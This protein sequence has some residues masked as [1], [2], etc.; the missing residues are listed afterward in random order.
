[1][2]S[3][4][5]D[6]GGTQGGKRDPNQQ[7]SNSLLRASNS[8]VNTNIEQGGSFLDQAKRVGGG[9][10][11]TTLDWLGRPGQAVL[12]GIQA[13]QTHQGA[14]GILRGL[15]R[16]FTGGEHG[17]QWRSD[18]T[19]NLRG[20]L[21]TDNYQVDGGRGGINP[22]AE[23]A[24]E[25]D[26]A[27]KGLGGPLETIGKVATG[28]VDFLGSSVLDPSTFVT[29]G[30][31]KAAKVGAEAAAKK[32]A[33]NGAE[34]I[35]TKVAANAG[36]RKI[37]DVLTDDEM[38]VLKTAIKNSDE[39]AIAKG[40][41]DKFT[42]K[43]LRD[44]DKPAGVRFAGKQVLDFESLRPAA[45][46]TRLVG[47]TD[48]AGNIVNRGLNN[49]VGDSRIVQA[50]GRA[51]TPRYEIARQYGQ[52]VAD[53]VGRLGRRAGA[54]E[55]LNTK[56]A[57]DDLNRVV[58][59][60]GVNAEEL[61]T[62][63]GTAKDNGTL[64]KLADNFAQQGDQGRA[65]LAE[66]LAK[67]PTE[68]PVTFT[69]KGSRIFAEAA[70]T[71]AKQGDLFGLGGKVAD[72]SSRGAREAADALK[73][74][75]GEE[76]Q[77][78]GRRADEKFTVGEQRQLFDTAA[79][80]LPAELTKTGRRVVLDRAADLSRRLNVPTAEINAIARTGQLPQGVTREAFEK[81]AQ[82]AA[83]SPK[84]MI[85]KNA[86]KATA[87]STQRA[88]ADQAR[89]NLFKG[90]AGIKDGAGNSMLS[91]VAKNG[92]EAIK[93]SDGTTKYIPS[94]IKKEF[95][96]VES[97]INND[98]SIRAFERV[99][100]GWQKWWRATA[101]VPVIGGFGFHL[102]NAQG[103]IF[104]NFLAGVEDPAVYVKA[105]KLQ[106]AIEKAVRSDDN[107]ADAIRK[108][109]LSDRDVRII[110]EA[111][112]RGTIGD[113][114]VQAD[115]E[116]DPL[117]R[118]TSRTVRTAKGLNPFDRKNSYLIRSGTY[119]GRQV[120]TNARL[121]HFIDKVNKTGSFEQA[122]ESVRKY[123]FDYGDLTPIEQKVF[124]RYVPFYTYL[125]KNTPLQFE[126]LFTQPGKY[127]AISRLYNEAALGA[128]DTN[129]QEIPKY[130]LESGAIPLAG[131]KS[132]M[133]LSVDTPFS[134]AIRA[135]QPAV[136]VAGLIGG[137]KNP[138]RPEGGKEE[139]ARSVIN[140]AGGGPVELA[141]FA[142]SQA[143]GKDL[144]T[145]A[146]ISKE[147]D[148]Q[149]ADRLAKALSPLYGKVRGVQKDAT[150]SEVGDKQ[151]RLLDAITGA[152]ATALTEKRSQSETYRKLDIVNKAIAS[153]KADGTDV[154][155]TS[156]LQKAG[157]IPKTPKT[158]KPKKAKV[159]KQKTLKSK[160]STTLKKPKTVKPKKPP[161]R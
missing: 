130:L 160:K 42:E 109:G 103:N 70:P 101:T 25:S 49:V 72:A 63:F 17:F 116:V 136:N 18:D 110:E 40:G 108:Q 97:I 55:A 92:Y 36:K 137:K 12:R 159:K 69:Q 47:R 7:L 161:T 152:N 138:L 48:E 149:T 37:S 127:T 107:F 91:D 128:A 57:I 82:E 71:T 29:A 23:A 119:I 114:L 146:D 86:L 67:V 123:L 121:A 95:S 33:E 9:G 62:V 64:M 154:P 1:M 38:K 58:K 140:Q 5:R 132:P 54:E 31:S 24:A 61:R 156:E 75:V 100:D 34:D 148:T 105:G 19:T 44:L 129:G 3:L 89:D 157:I 66:A 51:L 43:A 94:E 6:T 150:S 151:S 52:N 112:K 35:A 14:G 74:R 88:F 155:S 96:R 39:A 27:G 120:E 50:T 145:G 2:A 113:F 73:S 59:D 84:E 80:K 83:R 99:I 102:R 104:N 141:K 90:L 41:A 131:G 13:Q 117:V 147:S 126:Q 28:T 60:S 142:L 153:A 122:D 56:A 143:T 81:A 21:N 4:L 85:E 115:Q 139:A 76:P 65:A 45:E 68:A 77:V 98:E 125:R 124:R 106:T 32:L 16:G 87:L 158:T 134:A 144:F 20:A 93:L 26:Y 30:G 11:L 22:E 10:L 46:T 111:R 79:T 78:V 8:D 118:D 133:L 53:A 15:G 135:V